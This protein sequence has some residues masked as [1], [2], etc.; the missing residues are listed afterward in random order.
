[1]NRIFAG[2]ILLTL[3][4]ISFVSAVDSLNAELEK[5]AV[6][7][8]DLQRLSCY[9]IL[10][11]KSSSYPAEALTV[12]SI[13]SLSEKN[14]LVAAPKV[15]E[16]NF[17]LT[18]KSASLKATKPSDFGLETQSNDKELKSSIPGKF[19]GWKGGDKLT[20]A[21]GQV[22]QISDSSFKLFHKSTNPKI[23]IVKGVFDSY[24][25]RIDGLNKTA[26]VIRIK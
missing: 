4:P 18:G 9:D 1:M 13:N 22:W 14:T 7:T 26:Q 23:T 17:G 12:R 16:N 11:G 24:R 2:I 20:L 19:T 6:M 8:R 3:V 21:N 10:S 25:I 5:C 15:E